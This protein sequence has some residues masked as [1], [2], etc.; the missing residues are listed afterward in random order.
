MRRDDV[1]SMSIRRHFGTFAHWDYPF[2]IFSSDNGNILTFACKNIDLHKQMFSY[3]W[4]KSLIVS[5]V[6]TDTVVS[7]YTQKEITGQTK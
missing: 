5:S 7:V 1:A 6:Y 2:T 3:W 4:E